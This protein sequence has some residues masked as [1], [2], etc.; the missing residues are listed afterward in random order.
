MA[1][2]Y[3]RKAALKGACLDGRHKA[4]ICEITG[5]YHSIHPVV[6]VVCVI[7]TDQLRNLGLRQI[8]TNYNVIQPTTAN[9][10]SASWSVQS[11]LMMYYR[12]YK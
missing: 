6:V 9:H 12:S 10:L 1:G 5:Y 11:C 8:T 2:D 7:R 3:S 4:F